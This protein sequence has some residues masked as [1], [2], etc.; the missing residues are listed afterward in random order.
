MRATDFPAR[1]FAFAVGVDASTIGCLGMVAEQTTSRC[2]LLIAPMQTARAVSGY[3]DHVVRLW[4]QRAHGDPTPRALV[5]LFC[6]AARCMPRCMHHAVLCSRP[7]TLTR[8]CAAEAS[9]SALRFASHTAWVRAPDTPDTPA[10]IGRIRAGYRSHRDTHSPL[11]RRG[12]QLTSVAW[13]PA[14]EYH[15][16]SSSLDGRIKVSFQ[17]RVA[18]P[19]QTGVLVCHEPCCAPPPDVA[20]AGVGYSLR[21]CASHNVATRGS[22]G[23]PRERE[24]ARK[25]EAAG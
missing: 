8:R 11:L 15:F 25:K 1:A 20:A 2:G 3:S 24:L 7:G 17:R 5:P 23:E 21:A 12:V 18:M 22:E 6:A 9:M 10:T 13:S 14:S 19:L 16:A 4:D